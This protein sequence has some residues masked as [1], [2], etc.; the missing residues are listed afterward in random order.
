VLP[1]MKELAQPEEQPAGQG[2]ANPNQQVSIC[3]CICA[4]G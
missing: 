1:V 3:L 2:A 4:G